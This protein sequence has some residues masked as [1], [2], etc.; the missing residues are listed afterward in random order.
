[1]LCLLF[2]E[3]RA[4]VKAFDRKS[5]FHK[6]FLK[7]KNRVG[8]TLFKY[9]ESESLISKGLSSKSWWL[10]ESY[11]P[12]Q[13][14]LEMLENAH[15]IPAY[16]ERLCILLKDI[17]ENL[18]QCLNELDRRGIHLFGKT[19][20]VIRDT[21][22][23]EVYIFLEG[24]RCKPKTRRPWEMHSGLLLLPGGRGSSQAQAWKRVNKGNRAVQVS[25]ASQA[26]EWDEG[27]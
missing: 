26:N 1:M 18:D 4:V 15:S 25:S 5:A 8:L 12:L 22:R 17:Y 19:G 21:I 10:S 27:R 24:F 6:R 11:M 20:R 9:S 16:K 2:R 13:L 3:Y 7:L 23:Y 14:E